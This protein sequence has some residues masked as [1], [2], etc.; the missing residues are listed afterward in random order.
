MN[1]NLKE[2]EEGRAGKIVGW[3][4]YYYSE[5]GSTNDEAFNLGIAG[6]P[7]GTVVVADSQLKGRG[8]FQRSWHSP[9]GTNIYTSVILRPSLKISES[10]RIPVM[11]G[12][13]VGDVLDRYCPGSISLK[14]PNDILVNEKKVSGILSQ[15]KITAKRIDF[16]VLGIGINVNMKKELF[17]EDIRDTATS[18]A[19]EAGREIAR[20]DVLISLYENLEKWYKQLTLNG[21]GSVKSRWLRMTSMIGRNVQVVFKDEIIEGKATDMDDNG[22]LILMVN[23]NKTIQISAGDAT[24][25][26]R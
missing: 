22:S 19:L 1:W 14:W 25:K 2:L 7:E 17:P 4:I 13:A 5:T 16:I 9:A 11:A 18:L 12:V 23:E 6:A 24:V 8:R 20:Q 26:K 15:A 10:S 21:F 3:K